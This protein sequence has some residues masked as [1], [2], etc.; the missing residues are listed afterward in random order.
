MISGMW[1][2]WSIANLLIYSFSYPEMRWLHRLGCILTDALGE[3]SNQ[4]LSSHSPSV[5]S[6]CWRSSWPAF[7]DMKRNSSVIEQGNS[8]LLMPNYPL[9]LLP[10]K[11]DYCNSISLSH[12]V[13]LT[14]ITANYLLT[15]LVHIALMCHGKVI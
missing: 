15:A 14:L 6:L 5:F 11:W 3:R 4:M 7:A 12:W 2:L 9:N 1:L 8:I 10:A 13:P